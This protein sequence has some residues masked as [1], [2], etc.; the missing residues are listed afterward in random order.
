[1]RKPLPPFG[2][3]E[4][5]N[6]RSGGQ[7]DWTDEETKGRVY[8]IGQYPYQVAGR[9]EPRARL[10]SYCPAGVNF[11]HMQRWTGC[12]TGCEHPY[13]SVS[14]LPTWILEGG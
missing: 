14:F 10:G 2:R 6:H 13:C 12:S 11:V 7:F 3:L 4:F 9:A 1:M 5:G 8:A